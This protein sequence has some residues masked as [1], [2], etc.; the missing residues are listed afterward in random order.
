MSAAYT[1]G[2][3]VKTLLDKNILV[4]GNIISGSRH[5]SPEYE[6]LIVIRI[7]LKEPVFM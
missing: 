1:I 4:T 3:A 2:Q 7:V 5:P 6:A